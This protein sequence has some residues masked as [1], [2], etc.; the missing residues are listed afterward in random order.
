MELNKTLRKVYLSI[1]LIILTIIQ[2]NAQGISIK[3]KVV[4]DQGKPII[5]ANVTIAGTVI[6]TTT[7]E[8]GMFTIK[9]TSGN[10]KLVISFV[11]YE[12]LEVPVDNNTEFNLTLKENFTK[13]DELVVMGYSEKKKSEITS[14]ISVVSGSDMRDIQSSDMTTMLQG[15]VTGVQIIAGTGQPGSPADIKIRGQSTF[16]GSGLPL[17]VIDGIPDSQGDPGIDPNMIESVTIL[18]DAGSTG[19]YGSRANAGVIVITTKKGT[20]ERPDI[21]VSVNAGYKTPF[22]GNFAMMTTA[23]LKA[24]R[25]TAYLNPVTRYN[26]T[27]AYNA[28]WPDTLNVNKRNFDWLHSVFTPCYTQTANLSVSGKSN[29]YNYYVGAT[30]YNEQGSLV[31]TGYQKLSFRSN[32]N[33]TFSDYV[34][35]NAN[36]E[37]D[38]YE[39]QVSFWEQTTYSVE[40]L[41]TDN[42]YD[43][44]GN[45]VIASDQVPVWK[46]RWGYNGLQFIHNSAFGINGV[47]TRLDLGLNV[48]ILPWLTFTSNNRFTYNTDFVYSIIYPTADDEWRGIG[49]DNQSTDFNLSFSLTDLLKFN[50][51]FGKHNISGLVGGEFGYSYQL[52]GLGGY[53][54]QLIP[55]YTS[56]SLVGNV[57]GITGYSQQTAGQSFISQVNYNYNEKYFL[58]GSYRVDVSSV[59][60]VNS[61]TAAFPTIS[62]SWLVNRE[63]FLRQITTIDNLKIRVSY[64]ITGNNNIQPNYYQGIYS[65]TISKTSVPSAGNVYT[66]TYDGSQAPYPQQVANNN[67][68]WEK[69]SQF[70]IG[71]DLGLIKRIE[72]SFDYYNKYTSNL[73][74]DENVTPSTGYATAYQNVGKIYNTGVELSLTGAVIKTKDIIWNLNFNISKNVNKAEGVGSTGQNQ[75]S[76]GNN[77]GSDVSALLDGQP[78][79]CFWGPKWLGVNRTDGACLWEQV[80]TNSSGQVTSRQPTEN[81]QLATIQNIGSPWPDYTGGFGTEFRYKFISL[82]VNFAYSEGN[83]VYNALR[84]DYDSDG[85]EGASL[86]QQKFLPGWLRWTKP[87]DHAS[88]PAFGASNVSDSHNFSSRYLEDG[89]FIK[90]RTVALVAHIPTKWTND[91]ITNLTVSISG[92]NL[93]TWSKFSGIDPETSLAL[94]DGQLPGQ[95]N[96]V[97]PLSR[98][99]MAAIKLN[100]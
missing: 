30:L 66:S 97:Y 90:L 98:I 17:Y 13:L 35:A 76:V 47:N 52:L 34:S 32:N 1:V 84:E 96:G 2:I 6:G 73:L 40:N 27:A 75:A 79:W 14:A 29:K 74:W 64:G 65:Y 12:K 36:L 78:I 28:E 56:L 50:K 57:Q 44:H 100:F 38:T 69:T 39:Q 80:T 9:V 63:E 61:R 31:T 43:T 4:D 59:F 41:P 68:T 81:F 93:M 20:T 26:N 60:P 70:N 87:G 23:E 16:T 95:A 86:N 83:K 55:G 62:G 94:S 11:G 77:G 5:G 82:N 91:K 53:G 99:F 45:L 8:K 58:S 92:N 85:L 89:S 21:E 37:L 54:S 49:T 33:Y 51:S 24:Y 88:H 25:Q 48:K 42:P 46:S 71:F 7:D 22:F 72:I 18:K 19:M 3:G 10:D 15:K 67:L